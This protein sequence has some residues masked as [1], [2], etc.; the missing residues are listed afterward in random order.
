[1]QELSAN[2]RRL[3]AHL[4]R[5]G[6]A[7]KPE[8]AS[9]R[10]LDCGWAT[11]TKLVDGLLARG[12][13]EPVGTRPRPGR[14]GR[15]ARLYRLA[16]QRHGALGIDVEW[17]ATTAVFTA[18]DGSPRLRLELQTPAIG[19]LAA[20]ARFLVRTARAAL[21]RQPGG[22]EVD[23]IGIGTV[24]PGRLGRLPRQAYAGLAAQVS[25][26]LALPCAVENNIA[27]YGD[28]LRLERGLPDFALIAIRTG[29]GGCVVLDNALRRGLGHA[30]EL[31]HL[32]SA[33]TRRCACG[34]TG[35]LEAE[36]GLEALAAC[37]AAHGGAPGRDPCDLFRLQDPA[38]DATRRHLARHLAGAFRGLAAALDP[39]LLLVAGRFGSEGREL[40]GLV[41]REEPLLRGRIRYVDL[42]P[43]DL[44]QA[45]AQLFHRRFFYGRPPGD[46]LQAPAGTVPPD[47]RHPA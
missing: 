9:P 18:L 5:A 29:V 43:E 31:G 16:A 25:G 8:L 13:L 39:P 20:L 10:G 12:F 22:F 41:A 44:I 33:G 27:S 40:P 14:Y 24:M 6:S 17:H 19:S 7:G 3:L 32:Q 26:A 35:C 47:V 11:A 45:A 38:A 23:G 37:Y 36:I 4:R 1:M 46:A 30:G 28:F 34:R 21:E 15:N 2:E 42:R